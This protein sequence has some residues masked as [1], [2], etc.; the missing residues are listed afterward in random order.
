MKTLRIFIS[1]RVQGVGF[2]YFAK[3][4]AEKFNIRGFAENLP[5]GDVLVVAQGK[6]INDFL[7]VIRKG[8][9]HGKVKNVV[10]MDTDEKEYGEFNI[11]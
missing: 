7:D 5:N 1:G 9:P 8:P 3:S 4:M 6:K 2:R 10:A 11:N